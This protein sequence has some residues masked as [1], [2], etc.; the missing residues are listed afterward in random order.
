VKYTDEEFRNGTR[1]EEYERA[2]C[3]VVSSSGYFT[4][5]FSQ[6]IEMKVS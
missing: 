2:R 4:A 6:L 5:P 3:E 1:S